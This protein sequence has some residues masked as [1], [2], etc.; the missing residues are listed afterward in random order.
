[1][2]RTERKILIEKLEKVRESKLLCYV[3]G[4]RG[5]TPAQIGDDA[6]RPIYE[7][8]R[9]LGH[10]PRLD[11][12]IYSRGG[13]IDVPWRLVTAFVARAMSGT[14]SFLTARTVPRRSSLLELTT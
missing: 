8:L 3:V 12:F 2:A 5:P 11:L 9:A 13:A 4:D 1:V 14:S 6:L 7:H 10:V